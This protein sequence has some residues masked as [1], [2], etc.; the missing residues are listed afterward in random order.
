MQTSANLAIANL[1]DDTAR[2]LGVR[3]LDLQEARDKVADR[4]ATGELTIKQA[5][6]ELAQT[7]G[8]RQED[9]L[10]DMMERE[11]AFKYEEMEGMDAFRN[12]QLSQQNTQWTAD[13]MRRG[14][15]EQRAWLLNKHKQAMSDIKWA[16]E[17]YQFDS[18]A[19]F[20][21]ENGINLVP[22]IEMKMKRDAAKLAKK[23]LATGS[24]AAL[25]RQ[26]LKVTP[27]AKTTD[28]NKF[29]NNY[30]QSR[31]NIVKEL[32]KSRVDEGTGLTPLDAG[33]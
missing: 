4:I 20:A 13:F 15:N 16:M 32:S 30:H 21:S 7:L 18:A 24:V 9:R 26:H 27:G 2:T 33:I 29:L 14:K 25:A 5:A 3:K 17:N 23:D 28:V 10:Q 22:N 6:Q 19:V 8:V 31:V 11:F 12:A 1:Q